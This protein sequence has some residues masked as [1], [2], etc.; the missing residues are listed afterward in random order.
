MLWDRTDAEMET[1]TN[2]VKKNFMF[3]WDGF[4]ILFRFE[5]LSKRL[6]SLK[7]CRT[8]WRP[9][10]NQLFGSIVSAYLSAPSLIVRITADFTAFRS[11]PIVILPE[12]PGKPS[13]S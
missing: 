9:D 2:S 7:T 1:D 8:P 3:K 4:E 6:S 5:P 13:V 11:L 10:S 12:T